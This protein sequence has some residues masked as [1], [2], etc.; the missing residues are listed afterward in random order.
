MDWRRGGPYDIRPLNDVL[1]VQAAGYG[2]G[3]LIYANVQMR[4]PADAIDRLGRAVRAAWS[5][6]DVRT[7]EAMASAFRE[8]R[9]GE[10]ELDGLVRRVLLAMLEERATRQPLQ[11]KHY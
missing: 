5:P 3:S 8:D 6:G 10:T 9:P 1:V 7:L 11:G 2:G 4:P